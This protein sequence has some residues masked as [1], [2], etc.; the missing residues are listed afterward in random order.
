MRIQHRIAS[1]CLALVFAASALTG[2]SAG[3]GANIIYDSGS[4]P[5]DP[6]TSLSFFGYKYEALNVTAIEDA[7]HGFMDE[8]PDIT[9]SYDGIKSPE[10]FDILERRLNTGNGDDI[11]MVDHERVLELGARSF[12]R[13]VGIV[14]PG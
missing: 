11:I 5:T 12:G 7:L 6:L 14:H 9:I 3:Q 1:V 8:H 4:Q 13:S 2:C 10:Y